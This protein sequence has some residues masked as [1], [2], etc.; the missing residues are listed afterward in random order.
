VRSH[1]AFMPIDGVA[2]GMQDAD[3][4][5]LAGS[6]GGIRRGVLI[7]HPGH[8]GW[9]TR[10]PVRSASGACGSPRILTDPYEF[11][12]VAGRKSDLGS[13]ETSI[14]VGRRNRGDSTLKPQCH[15]VYKVNALE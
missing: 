7:T 10:R 3:A 8:S 12:L 6:V 9:R 15:K 4:P 2:G 5:L 14:S 1:D 11:G 13:V